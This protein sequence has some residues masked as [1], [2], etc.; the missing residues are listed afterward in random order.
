MADRVSKETRSAIMASVKSKN[1]KPEIALR[2]ALHKLGYRFRLHRR[3]LPGSPDLVF[4]SRKKAIFVH[5]CFW[6]GHGCRWGKL[7]KSRLEYWGPKIAA[8]KKRD[9]N[10]ARLL[11]QYGWEAK[12]VWA[13]QL[14]IENK[15]LNKIAE[16]LG[17]ARSS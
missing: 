11:R 12:T 8:N 5:G 1:T 15:T 3:D 17:H 10:K 2:S 14:R 13:C 6:H 7:P 9:R 4:P 16:F